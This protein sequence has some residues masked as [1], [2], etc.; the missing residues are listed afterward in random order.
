MSLDNNET[1][2]LRAEW[3][4]WW[5]VMLFSSSI[6]VLYW[7][8]WFHLTFSRN[9]PVIIQIC[10]C[11][12]DFVATPRSSVSSSLL[13]MYTVQVLSK[14]KTNSV[15]SST[16][17]LQW[18]YP[19]LISRIDTVS[20]HVQCRYASNYIHTCLFSALEWWDNQCI[21]PCCDKQISHEFVS[22]GSALTCKF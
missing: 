5:M 3:W 6:I 19:L 13:S 20:R 14:V 8:S 1:D 15:I 4:W 16:E 10:I 2:C 18:I 21:R 17:E 9:P 12:G 22:S 11:I 7:V